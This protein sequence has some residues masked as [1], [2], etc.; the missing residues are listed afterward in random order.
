MPSAVKA[1]YWDS[2][3]FLSYVDA[4]PDR[5][6]ALE[7]LLTSSARGETRLY[8]SAISQVEV[9]FGSSERERQALDPNVERQIDSL[10]ADPEVVAVV[11]YHSFI[12]EIAKGM[13]RDAVARGWS[14]KPVDAIQLATTQWLRSEGVAINEFHTYDRRLFK[15]ADI[16]GFQILEPYIE[17]PG[18]F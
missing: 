4:V 18:L 2:D 17:Q 11:D 10:W 1:I 15:Y 3:C 6:A 13:I 9:A 8:T 16:C 14:L 5:I 7:T 12:G